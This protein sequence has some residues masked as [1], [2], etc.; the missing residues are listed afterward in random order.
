MVEDFT[1]ELPS[2]D[3]LA[4]ASLSTGFQMRASVVFAVLGGA[5]EKSLFLS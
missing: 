2:E 5:R 1:R 3:F 4:A